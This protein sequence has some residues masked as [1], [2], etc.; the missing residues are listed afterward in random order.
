M[1]IIILVF[2][3]LGLLILVNSVLYLKYAFIPKSFIPLESKIIRFEERIRWRDSQRNPEVSKTYY[4]PVIEYVFNDKK[5]TYQG[6]IP[7]RLKTYNFNRKIVLYI[8]PKKPS[9]VRHK[10]KGYWE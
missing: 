2:S 3:F 10:F 1:L 7:I 9:D 6:Q 5:H 8:N 4:T